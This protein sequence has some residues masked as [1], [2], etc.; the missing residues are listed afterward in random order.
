VPP[1]VKMEV[2]N[3]PE[4]QEKLQE[5]EHELEVSQSVSKQ[6]RSVS[7]LSR[8]VGPQAGC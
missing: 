4:L 2:S 7:R 5:L 6:K 1:T 3:H 8:G